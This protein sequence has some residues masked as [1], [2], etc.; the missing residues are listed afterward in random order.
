MPDRRH[1]RLYL[2]VSLLL[3]IGGF[4]ALS[5]I[6][7]VSVGATES[8][9]ENRFGPLGGA[10]AYELRQ[11]LG[12][13]VY[14]FLAGWLVV[15]VR[16]VLRRSWL[17]WSLRSL[18]WLLLVPVAAVLAE[19]NPELA[20]PCSIPPLGS[21]GS[22]GGWLND[23]MNGALPPMGQDIL[24][25]S[26]LVLGAVLTLDVELR[27]LLR[28]LWQQ[29]RPNFD[30]SAMVKRLLPRRSP[31]P[32][33]WTP[34]APEQPQVRLHVE[35][36]IEEDEEEQANGAK[37]IPIHHHNEIVR[38]LEE[39][40]ERFAD[41]K[42]PSLKLL[43]EPQPF[44]Y[45]AHDQQLR[46]RAALLEK[47]FT[48]FDLNVHVV[49]I[50][51]GPVVTQ[52]EIALEKGLRVQKVTR[53]AE[54]IA[55]N[56]KVP[57]VRIVAPIPGKNTVGI[58]VPNELRANVRL[59]EVLLASAKK[60]AKFQIP[61]FL[62]KDSEGRPLV[63]DLADMPHLLIAGT[64]GTG[65]S[66]CLNTIILSILMTRRPDEVKM[67]MLDPK[68]GVEMEVYSKIPHLMHPIV[69]DMK[70]SEAILAWAV[71]KME[72]RYDLLRRARVRNIAGY[73]ELKG[74]E[75]IR[76]VKPENDE[77]RKQI[78]LHMPYI[79]I[80]I[81]EMADLMLQM[82]REVEGHIIRLAQKSRAAGIHLVVATQKPTVDVITGLIKSNLPSRIC[83]K[84]TNKTDSRVVLDA[85]G[86][87]KLLGKGDMLF[88]PPGTSDLIRAQ[89]TYASDKEI[90]AVVN[91][92]E[93]EP[94]YA[95][96]LMELQVGDKDGSVADR[97][98]KRE[99]ELYEAAIEIILREGRG[100]VSL[101]QR[102]LGIGYGR[103]ARLID[104]MAEDGIVGAYNGSNAREV[105]Y[106]PEQWA[107]ARGAAAE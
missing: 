77:E 74:D 30:L 70:K 45:R 55:I 8:A 64:T 11:A 28:L 90:Q 68:G 49:G 104:F 27:L 60:S 67:I 57:S 9:R 33:V 32:I 24:L 99:D 86:A 61:L 17:G 6:D 95:P 37:I 56:L 13:A 96:E 71:D 79:V 98:G 21:G 85:M 39:D 75:I 14:V 12:A 69:T 101:L 36:E 51:T 50:N 87:D 84:V 80:V 22:I 94:C 82:K 18:G 100:S 63:G 48:D 15:L 7:S 1:W 47:T 42:L 10:L 83:F 38:P 91:V 89:G 29:L 93:S 65:K 103:A 72:E 19:R 81:D 46:E 92:L 35:P 44:D 66:V 16:L 105:L 31:P 59:K 52:F 43:E 54:D 2:A 58:E 20:P 107:T 106:T 62:G 73:N 53:L 25:G 40:R 3:A 23:W 78:P 4:L 102:A 5:V 34:V 97:L 76:R 88:L 26:C 41:Y